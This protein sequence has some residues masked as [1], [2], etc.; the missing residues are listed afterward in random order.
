[1]LKFR[2]Y[3]KEYLTVDQHKAF[4]SIQM[5]PDARTATDHFFGVGNDVIHHDLHHDEEKTETHKKI[6]AHLGTTIPVEQYKKGK[7]RTPNGNE[8]RF[9]SLIKDKALRD[10]YSRDAT[11]INSKKGT[12]GFYLTTHRGLGVA[13]QT[14]PVPDELHPTGHSW[15]QQSCKNN[16]SGCNRDFLRPEIQHGTVV[17]FGHDQAGKEIYR[18]TLQPY[19]SK[20]GQQIY[21]VNSEYGLKH[22]AFTAHAHEVSKQLSGEYSPE[23]FKI[24][25]AVYNN[26]DSDYMLHPKTS[27]AQ[28]KNILQDPKSTRELKEIALQHTAITPEHIHLALKDKDAHVRFKAMRHPAVNSDNISVAMKDRSGMVKEQAIQHPNA[29]RAQLDDVMSKEDTE[30]HMDLKVAAMKNPNV[31]ADHVGTAMKSADPTL[32]AQAAKHPNATSAQIDQA[33]KDPDEN[34]NYAAMENPGATPAHL[35]FGLDSKDMVMRIAALRHRNV[36][37]THIERGLKDLE[38]YVRMAA[39]QSP[40]STEDHLKRSLLDPDQKVS[41]AALNQLKKRALI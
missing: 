19:K 12:S 26:S 5:R 35:H 41:S 8:R 32:R 36:D 14:N 21:G 9:G 18:S 38:K 27:S 15:A 29:T 24:H 4:S 25:P 23:L 31:T 39:V 37:S 6:E 2:Q 3:L 1:M 17:V 10:E 22:P 11:K 16:E 28:L 40:A 7:L 34:V 30:E 13:G 20:S 33:I